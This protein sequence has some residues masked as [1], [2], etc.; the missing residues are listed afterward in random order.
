MSP[1]MQKNSRTLSDSGYWGIS[2]TQVNCLQNIEFTTF[3]VKPSNIERKVARELLI[4]LPN[5]RVLDAKACCDNWI[6]Y[7]LSSLKEARKILVDKQVELAGYHDGGLY[8]LVELMAAGIRQFL[9]YEESLKSRDRNGRPCE[10]SE[11]HRTPETRKAYLEI[12]DQLRYHI[13]SSLTQVSKIAA[14][15]TP[16][17]RRYLKGQDAWIRS[18]YLKPETLLADN[19]K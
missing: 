3:I 1:G 4:R 14:M 6:D 19:G 8:L 2:L 18:L 9:T 10:N 13:Q 7:A 5:K 17:V 16:K 12:L 15:E 11:F